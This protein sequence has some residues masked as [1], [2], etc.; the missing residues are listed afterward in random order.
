MNNQ[1]QIIGFYSI[2]VIILSIISLA[3]GGYG[4]SFITN[5]DFISEDTKLDYSGDIFS[6]LGFL[7]FVGVPETSKIANALAI[8]RLIYW[9]IVIPYTILI[10]YIIVR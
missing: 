2:F 5:A 3:P 7:L 6:T 1:F 8:Y 4:E 10:S 9:I